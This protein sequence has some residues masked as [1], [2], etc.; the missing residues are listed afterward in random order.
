MSHN[1][2]PVHLDVVGEHQVLSWV[3]PQVNASEVMLRAA[4]EA[5]PTCMQS[6][7]LLM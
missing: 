5:E 4:Q 2:I 3:D 6:T 7:G 1:N